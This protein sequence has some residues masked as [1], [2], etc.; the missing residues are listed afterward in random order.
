MPRNI[1][2]YALA[3]SCGALTLIPRTAQPQPVVH[4]PQVSAAAQ[5]GISQNLR[6]LPDAT[7]PRATPQVRP[8][9]RI[10][11]PSAPV[12]PDPVLQPNAGP[13]LMP[14]PALNFMGMGIDFPGGFSLAGAPSSTNIAVGPNHV[15]QVVNTNIAVFDKSGTVVMAPKFLNVLWTGYTGT[16]PG[17]NCATRNDGDPIVQYDT[18]ADRWLV[19][20]FVFNVGSSPSYECVAVSQTSDPTG[21]YSLY[22]FQYAGIPDLPKVGVWPDAYYF[23]YNL[24]NEAFTLYL[25][26]NVCAMDRAKMLLGM[27]AAQHCFLT[28]NTEFGLL[29][30]DL[31]GATPPPAGAPNYL[32]S[33]GST[34]NTLDVWK[35]HV[36]WVTPANSTFTGPTVLATSAFADA[37]FPGDTC[38][39]QGATTQKLDARGDQLMYRLAYRNFGD[40]EALVVNH[41]IVAG[42][43]VGV[44][45]YEIRSPGSSPVIFQQGTY[46]P[47]S[48]YRWMGSI[49]MDHDGNMALGFSLSGA[50][51]KPAIHYTGRLVGDAAGTMGQ[52]EGTI[53]DSNGLQVGLSR[54]GDYTS[55]RIDPA[56]DCTFWYTNQYP[57]KIAAINWD[58]RIASFK[59]PTCGLAPTPVLQS[60]ASRHVHGAA[61]TF[62]L[63]LSTVVPPAIN[64]N[65]TTEPRVGPAQTLVFTFDKPLNAATVGVTEGTA[66]AG[67]PTFS[68]NSVV[69]GLT[70]VSDQQYVT[71][72]LTSVA[73][74]DGGI[75]GSATVRVGFLTG[76]TNSSRLVAVTDLVVVNAQLGKPLTAANFLSDVN[77]SGIITVLDKV[78]VN[79]ALGHFLPAP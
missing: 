67:A 52:G 55:M 23:T 1:V 62:D 58:T 9:L 6:D 70:G 35:F 59:F 34:A 14:A 44:R 75:G 26:V 78:F 20:Q 38:I 65:P 61:G 18:I 77:G 25:G 32:L 40:H 27:P 4:G 11:R 49:A 8:A 79:N 73:S 37:C 29:P 28:A 31:D 16:N 72:A 60:A 21:A 12:A 68:G 48:D 3:A 2:S 42:L 39:P 22:D 43:S 66:T 74:T 71:V 7:G 53:F 41:S 24:Y 46:A 64:H 47:D 54:W 10:P 56:D 76:D 19:S 17:N 5:A 45:W 36:D 13:P 69:V 51:L 30:A 15:V 50:A 57:S 33:L 63:P